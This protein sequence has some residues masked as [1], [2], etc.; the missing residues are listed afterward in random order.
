[1]SKLSAADRRGLPASA[2]VFPDRAPGPG[3]YPI[4]DRGHAV[5]ALRD[6]AGTKDAAAVRRAV[7]QKFGIGCGGKRS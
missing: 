7:C 4:P 6:S 1:M 5:I 2:F 3:S